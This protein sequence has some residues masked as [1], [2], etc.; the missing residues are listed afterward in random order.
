M[1]GEKYQRSTIWASVQ[2][3]PQ[4]RHGRAVG[5]SLWFVIRSE[6]AVIGPRQ[7]HWCMVILLLWSDT[8]L[9]L[10]IGGM[11][12]DF[13]NKN[14]TFTTKSMLHVQVKAESTVSIHRA[15]WGHR[16]RLYV[17]KPRDWILMIQSP[18]NLTGV[19]TGAGPGLPHFRRIGKLKSPLDLEVQAPVW[20]IVSVRPSNAIICNVTS[21]LTDWA[22]FQND[23]WY[24]SVN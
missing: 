11:H 23:R 19:S 22:H 14:N 20:T 10:C 7:E 5:Q 3:D 17:S 8:G 21:S 16:S 12:A 6:L 18:W 24:V 13:K 4:R 9:Y 2:T 1:H 15:I